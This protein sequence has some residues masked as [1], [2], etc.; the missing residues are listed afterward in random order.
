MMNLVMALH[1]PL[2]IINQLKTKMY[3]RTEHTEK[4][5]N[6]MENVMMVADDFIHGTWMSCEHMPDEDAIPLLK[7]IDKYFK[8]ASTAI[9]EYIDAMNEAAD[10]VDDNKLIDS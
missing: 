6:D 9:N 10:T 3:N 2:A 1:T 8:K 7:L 5:W 4:L